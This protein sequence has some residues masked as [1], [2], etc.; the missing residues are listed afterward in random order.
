VNTSAK[1]PTATPA[2]IATR[3]AA[4]PCRG[5]WFVILVK[6]DL[7]CQVVGAELARAIQAF[8]DTAAPQIDAE[9]GAEGVADALHACDGA[10]IIQGFDAWPQS[11]WRK[12]DA[13]RS[14]LHRS[15][16]T[17][18]ILKQ[19]ALESLLRDAPNLASWIGGSIWEHAPSPEL[20]ASEQEGRLEALRAWSGLTDEEVIARAS[21]RTLAADPEYAEWLVL[22]RRGDLLER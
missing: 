4:R 22:L 3:L 13:L 20:S 11:E 12:L 6:G 19:H 10:V 5:D 21:V 1:L 8:A 18:L 9:G 17:I 7:E 2:D 14:R 15:E 16:R